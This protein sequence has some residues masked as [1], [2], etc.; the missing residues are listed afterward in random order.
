M[1]FENRYW[2]NAKPI[3]AVVSGK[4][5][6]VL[7][8]DCVHMK[9]E[10]AIERILYSTVDAIYTDSPDG[11]FIRKLLEFGLPIYTPYKVPG[12]RMTYLKKSIFQFP[13][14]TAGGISKNPVNRAWKRLVDIAGGIVGSFIACI[15]FTILAI[16]IMIDSPGPVIYVQNR[17]GYDGRIFKFYKFR[18][19]QKDADI[20]KN[21]VMQENMMHGPICKLTNDPRVTRI[22]RFLRKH[23]LDE[24]PQFFAVLRGDMSIVGTRPPTIDEYSRYTPEQKSRLCCV[25]GITGLWQ[26]SGRN[27]IRDF[28]RIVELDRKYIKRSGPL[29]DIFII[30]RTVL[31]PGEGI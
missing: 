29:Y 6:N 26:V 8:A 15:L 7:D 12:I 19:M 5:I 3:V 20:R 28:D 23:S 24:F 2:G 1:Q 18:T 30:L 13:V 11:A 9:K 22:G 27:S 17:I 31:H 25:P 21:G 4:Q 16:P 10:G 14:W